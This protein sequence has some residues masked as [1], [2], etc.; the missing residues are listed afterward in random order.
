MV[1]V[2][3]VLPDNRIYTRVAFGDSL[4]RN[5]LPAAA[6]PVL[7]IDGM[8]AYCFDK[9]VVY[10]DY[11]ISHDMQYVIH[12]LSEM[13]LGIEYRSLLDGSTPAFSTTGPVKPLTTSPATDTVQMSEVSA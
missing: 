13:G 10:E 4:H 6:G 9:V 7:G 8:P 12:L 11:G 2:L 1:P 3:L 5:E